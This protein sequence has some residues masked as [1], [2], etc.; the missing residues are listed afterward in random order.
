MGGGNFSLWLLL[1][2]QV[3]LLSSASFSLIAWYMNYAMEDYTRCK[4]FDE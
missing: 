1:Y 4:K 3:F 2:I